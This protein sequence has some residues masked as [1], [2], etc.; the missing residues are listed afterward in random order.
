[1]HGILLRR[2]R[3][4]SQR[5][6][7]R[8]CRNGTAAAWGARRCP[9]CWPQRPLRGFAMQKMEKSWMWLPMAS[10][11]CFYP[12]IA[13]RC[14]RWKW[15]LLPPFGA[16]GKS[17][18]S[19]VKH[20]SCCGATTKSCHRLVSPR[21]RSEAAWR[22]A[23]LKHLVPTPLQVAEQNRNPCKLQRFA[24]AMRPGFGNN[25]GNHRRTWRAFAI[26]V[27]DPKKR[28][29]TTSARVAGSCAGRIRPSGSSQ[30]CSQMKLVFIRSSPIALR[31]ISSPAPNVLRCILR[32]W[33]PIT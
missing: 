27:F 12:A 18:Q 26:V 2:R 10:W 6:P 24:A 3:L 22:R 8:Q 19:G 9:C 17:T 28:F 23:V 32:W 31:M 30:G 11:K 20:P 4:A 5:W 29:C 1:M 25:G 7:S 33:Y 14:T 15:A 16:F 21:Q 13:S